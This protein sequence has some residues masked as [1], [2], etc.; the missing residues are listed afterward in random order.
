MPATNVGLRVKP[1][2][3]ALLLNTGSAE[4]IAAAVGK[5]LDDPALAARL[6]GGAQAFA[7]RTWRWDRQGRLLLGFLERLVRA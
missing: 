2:E 7:Q 4:E 3:E 5:I 6:A 1:G